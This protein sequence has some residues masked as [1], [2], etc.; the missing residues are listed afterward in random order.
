MRTRCC[1]SAVTSSPCTTMLWRMTLPSAS[2]TAMSSFPSSVWLKP[3]LTRAMARSPSS[4]LATSSDDG[5]APSL[6]PRKSGCVKGRKCT[7]APS[8]RLCTILKMA[9][10]AEA[11]LG[12]STR[13]AATSS[14]GS[15][16]PGAEPSAAR[17]H[18]STSA[19]SVTFCPAPPLVPSRRRMLRRSMSACI[20]ASPKT[21]RLRAATCCVSVAMATTRQARS[22][23]SRALA[24]REAS[25]TRNSGSTRSGPASR[26]TGAC[27]RCR[28]MWENTAPLAKRSF[29]PPALSVEMMEPAASPVSAFAAST[30]LS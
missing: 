25:S 8:T 13:S 23:T 11:A 22:S 20:C 28:M 18:S 30:G 19:G 4:R 14:L 9:W 17:T 21:R 16:V 3:G 1:S 2:P 10:S 5:M 29:A 12:M 24:K 27:S 6:R 26:R 15:S 7:Q